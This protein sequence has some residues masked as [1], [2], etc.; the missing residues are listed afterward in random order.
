MSRVYGTRSQGRGVGCKSFALRVRGA[1]VLGSQ[2]LL[3]FS[4]LWK[5]GKKRLDSSRKKR[6]KRTKGKKKRE[7]EPNSFF[8]FISFLFLKDL[9]P[10]FFFSFKKKK[11]E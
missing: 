4:F 6:E 1:F 9:F 11:R 3:Y 2:K 7:R 5:L 10:I 8:H